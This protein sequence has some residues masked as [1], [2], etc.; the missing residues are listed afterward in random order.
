VTFSFL[1]C[2]NNIYIYSPGEID[3][4]IITIKKFAESAFFYYKTDDIYYLK[5]MS[6]VDNLKTMNL[7]KQDK[8][9]M[10]YALENICIQNGGQ[11]VNKKHPRLSD[12][13]ELTIVDSNK[14][15]PNYYGVSNM[16]NNTN[17]IDNANQLACKKEES[18]LYFYS[19]QEYIENRKSLISSHGNDR[20]MTKVF[21]TF[22]VLN[23]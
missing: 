8:E 20:L 10:T 4:K 13:I 17:T 19:L 12:A 15:N 18:Y 22:L 6:P 9:Y 21:N 3:T 11:I 1:G 14:R 23:K 2:S 16:T 7:V 5:S